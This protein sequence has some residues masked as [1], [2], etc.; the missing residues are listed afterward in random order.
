M[1][2]AVYSV[3]Y[4]QRLERAFSIL[5]FVLGI[6][7]PVGFYIGFKEKSVVGVPEYKD[8]TKARIE[9]LLKAKE[10]AAVRN[11]IKANNPRLPYSE[12]D[13]IA[14]LEREMAIK[15]NVPL[16]IGLAI[17]WKESTFRPGAISPTGPLGLKQ[18]AHSWWG[19]ECGVSKDEL[20][21][22]KKNLDCG[23][24]AAAKYKS[25]YGDWQ[26]A[27]YHYHGHPTDVQ[28]NREY[29]LTVLKKASKIQALIG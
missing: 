2:H 23:Y 3:K 8:E 19:A 7:I 4:V 5:I 10:E 27:L 6:L 17:T 16:H 24:K 29:A 13:K 14:R 28:L 11:F 1:T 21:E 12:V 22:I 15:Y 20:L 26:T 9:A 25:R 18:V